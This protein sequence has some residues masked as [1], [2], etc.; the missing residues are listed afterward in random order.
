[1]KFRPLRSLPNS[2]IVEIKSGTCVTNS[3]HDKS[4]G[5]VATSVDDSDAPD[6]VV[7]I[8]GEED[9]SIVD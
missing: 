6:V 4:I 2:S 5:A 1:M 3:D 9:V 8:K 7:V